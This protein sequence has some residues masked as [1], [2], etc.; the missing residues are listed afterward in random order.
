MTYIILIER[1]GTT[2]YWSQYGGFV[3]DRRVAKEYAHGAA[4]MQLRNLHGIGK[5]GAE[6]KHWQGAR[7]E[8]IVPELVTT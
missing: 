3:A 6:H 2:E 4:L 5:Y 1:N 8:K 7:M